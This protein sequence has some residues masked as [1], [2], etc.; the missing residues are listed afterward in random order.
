[1]VFVPHTRTADHEAPIRLEI[2]SML[3]FREI[4]LERAIV[5]NVTMKT[6]KVLTVTCTRPIGKFPPTSEKSPL[7]LKSKI[8]V[9]C[10]PKSRNRSN[11]RV[12]HVGGGNSD[13]HLTD[14]LPG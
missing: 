2:R 9:N 14:Y 11:A 8:S 10:Q 5:G 1:V 6:G 3:K 7:S 12:S 13:E 4:V